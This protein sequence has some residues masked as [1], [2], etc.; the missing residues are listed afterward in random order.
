MRGIVIFGVGSWLVVDL[1][2]GLERAGISV[3]AAVANVPAEVRLL[4]R[5]PCIAREEVTPEILAVPYLVPLFTPAY[6]R[7]AVQDATRLGFSSPATF[8][9]PTVAVPRS[10]DTEPGVWANVG[11]TFGGASRLGRF[12]LINRRATIGHHAILGQFASI[13]PNA[14]LAGKVTI[15][16]GATVGAGVVVLPH[17]TVGEHA[18]VGAGSVVTHDVPDRSVVIGNPARVVRERLPGFGDD[19]DDPVTRPPGATT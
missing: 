11:A 6:R 12:V 10:L 17:I 3:A 13:G 7:R 4:D 14:T 16:Q 1:E 15:G 2:E 18:I 5:S 8:T 19:E 9:D